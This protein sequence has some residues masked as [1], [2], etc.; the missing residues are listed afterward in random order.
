MNPDFAREPALSG[1]GS[2]DLVAAER[3]AL[4]RLTGF[5]REAGFHFARITGISAANAERIA[6][7]FKLVLKRGEGFDFVELDVGPTNGGGRAPG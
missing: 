1:E 2:V 4:V 7:F 3:E 5:A 6:P